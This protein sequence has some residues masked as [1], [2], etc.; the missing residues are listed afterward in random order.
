MTMDYSIIATLGPASRAEETWSALVAAGATGFRL[1]TSHLTLPELA[2]WLERLDPF[3]S[4]FEPRPS[5]VLDLQGSKWRLGDFAPFELVTG[6]QVLLVNEAATAEGATL[7]VPHPDFFKAASVSS[8]EIAL[9]DA[10]IKLAVE[11]IRDMQIVTHVLLGG[12]ITPHKGIT[13]VSSDFRQES[14]SEKDQAILSQFRGVKSLRYAISYLKDGIETAKYRAFL[15]ME[16]YLIAKLERKPA[17]QDAAGIASIANEM[18]LCRGD[19]GAELGLSEMAK[20]VHRFSEKVGNLPVPVL[21]AGQVLEHMTEHAT[22]TRSE[23]AYLYETLVKGYH[24]VVLSDET[25]IGRYPVESCRMAALF[26]G[27]SD[28]DSHPSGG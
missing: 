21:M 2:I 25:A 10:K 1:N 3:L 24:G 19:L 17:L 14:L 22:P 4:K 12:L 23:I 6:E 8:A 7:P 5:L 13:F 9:N 28:G 27:S 15:S 20:E 16:D 18:W 11:S 26:K